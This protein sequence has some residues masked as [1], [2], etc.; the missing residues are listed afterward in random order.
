MASIVGKCPVQ[1]RFRQAISLSVDVCIAE[2]D[3][4]YN[5]GLMTEGVL[6]SILRTVMFPMGITLPLVA[7]SASNV[8]CAVTSEHEARTSGRNRSVAEEMQRYAL[9]LGTGTPCRADQGVS[10]PGVSSVSYR[11]RGVKVEKPKQVEHNPVCPYCDQE[12]PYLNS[13][14]WKK[15]DVLLTTPG[16]IAAFS[17]PNCRKLLS[18]A[19]VAWGKE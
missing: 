17:C 2:Y 9:D 6:G 11:G 3:P 5:L 12:I 8:M 13:H 19:S 10:W 18:V 14:G 15:K 4:I 16:S 7:S 1:E